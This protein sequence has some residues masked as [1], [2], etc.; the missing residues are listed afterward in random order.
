M[1]SDTTRRAWRKR[2][3]EPSTLLPPVPLAAGTAGAALLL[4]RASA[5]LAAGRIAAGAAVAVAEGLVPA[6][7][8]VA[9]G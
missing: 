2:E 9:R 8:M 7:A 1:F 4:P 5:A 6:S 3:S